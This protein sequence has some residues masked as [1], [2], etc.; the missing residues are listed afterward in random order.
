MLTWYREQGRDLPW[1]QTADPYA[2]WVSEIMLQQTQVN[3]VLPYYERWM[4][5]FPTAE[6]LAAAPDEEALALWQGLG[7]YRRCR[8]L[9]AGVRQVVAVG[10]PTSRAGWRLVAGVGDYTASAIASI[11]LGEVTAVVDGNVERVFARMTASPSIEGARRRAATSWATELIDRANPAEWNQAIMELGATVCRPG[12]PRCEECPVSSFC[13]SFAEGTM[14]QFPVANPR[15]PTI[16]V[17]W[18]VV[19]P[20]DG[21]RV[22]VSLLKERWWHGLWGFPQADPPG[23]PQFNLKHTVTHHRL[24][25]RVSIER[26]SPGADEDAYRWVGPDDL[27]T[28]PLPAPMRKII[29]RVLSTPFGEG[30]TS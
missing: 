9:L 7:Y 3:T 5:R 26:C 8:N 14:E 4:H 27:D 11:C 25:F 17:E 16:D 13:R 29:E 1:R 28:V 19:V 12:R 22:G 24:H 20:F 21:S 30:G 2:I 18:P 6:S 23:R 15:M 10:W